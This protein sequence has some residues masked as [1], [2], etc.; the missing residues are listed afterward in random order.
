MQTY[1]RG[2]SQAGQLLAGQ[3]VDLP[4]VYASHRQIDLQVG[5]VDRLHQGIYHLRNHGVLC[6]PADLVHAA[7]GP[8]ERGISGHLQDLEHE[9]RLE[10][11][12]CAIDEL[13]PL[14]VEAQSHKAVPVVVGDLAHLLKSSLLIEKGMQ[15]G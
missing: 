14:R 1:G 15:I 6:I 12:I 4:L 5:D 7:P 10:L 11:I 8:V 3:H 2:Q 9:I 13:R